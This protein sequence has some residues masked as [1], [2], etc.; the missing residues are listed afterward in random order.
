MSSL[1]LAQFELLEILARGGMGVVWKARHLATQATVA[2][3]VLTTDGID[4]DRLVDALHA[5]VDAMAGLRHPNIVYV[6]D[7]GM[8]PRDWDGVSPDVAP[9]SPWF[10]MEYVEG[11][12]LSKPH[13]TA[14]WPSLQSVL[15][16]LLDALAHAHARGVIH[17]DLK[18]SNVLMAC[19]LYTSPSPRD[20]E[21]SR[22]PSSA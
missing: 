20:V 8:V 14:D 10:A 15:V 11:T 4:T 7:Y 3:K 6:F 9:G 5:E 19:L 12:T 17:R 18:P 16:Q 2:V 13:W 1:V 22:M 21:E